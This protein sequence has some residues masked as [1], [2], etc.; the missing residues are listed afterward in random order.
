MS[1]REEE[2][3]I[4]RILVAL[5]TSRHSLAALQAAAELAC[6]FE[7]ELHGLFVEDVNLL[8]I[9][10]LPM[11]R[12]LQFPFATHAQMNPR[13]MRRQLRAQAHQARRA[14]S[15]ICRKREI[16]WTFRVVRGSVPS[17]VLKAAAEADLLCVGRASRPLTQRP[18]MGSTA[19]AAATDRH[20]SVLLISRGMRIA[21]PVVVTY[22]GSRAADRALRLARQLSR[23]TGGFLSILVPADASTPPEEL[24]KQ[25]NERLNSEDLVVG[26]RELTGSGVTSIIGGVQT[27]G[28]GTVVVSKALLHRDEIDQLLDA[29]E[30]PVAL[31]E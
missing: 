16:E 1:E 25:V 26:Y 31:T 21:P 22:N 19:R 11:A 12:E 18:G 2:L 20:Q 9:A 24:R 14:L 6:S 5:D 29:L 27:E 10:A 3:T 15:S 17:Q 30:C 23:P 7:A 4:E 8:R 28:C 13:R